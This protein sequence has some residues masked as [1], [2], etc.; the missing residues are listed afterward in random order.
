V[1]RRGI[2]TLGIL[3]GIYALIGSVFGALGG[4]FLFFADEP[5]LYIVGGV[6]TLLGSIFLILGC[7][8]LLIRRWRRKRETALVEENRYIW[9]RICDIVPNCNVRI[10]GRSP[11]V[12]VARYTDSGGR[13]H[14]FRS[15]NIRYYRD[16]RLLDKQVRIYIPE[17][18]YK[19][20]YMDVQALLPDI[21]EH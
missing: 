16:E 9:A 1:K 15:G 2:S 8:F 4:A 14:L 12:F 18:G 11:V 17:K 7:V 13:E 3:G 10:N 5:D 20:Y 21:V 19:P 6:F